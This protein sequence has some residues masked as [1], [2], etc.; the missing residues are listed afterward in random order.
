MDKSELKVGQRVVLVVDLTED[1]LYTF[2]FYNPVLV[3]GTTGTVVGTGNFS[4]SLYEAA[5][6]WDVPETYDLHTCGGLID[7]CTGYYVKAL[8]IEPLDHE[9]DDDIC[10][11][12]V[13]NL[14]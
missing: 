12:A 5:V 2:G 1:S 4:L 7:S 6:Q 13:S 11:S 8:Y 10:E 3:P 14:F 9:Y